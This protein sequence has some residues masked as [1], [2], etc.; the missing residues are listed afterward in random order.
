MQNSSDHDLILHDKKLIFADVKYLLTFLREL[1]ENESHY[2][3]TYKRTSKNSK[4]NAQEYH[5][6][7]KKGLLHALDVAVEEFNQNDDTVVFHWG[8]YR[9]LFQGQ[10]GIDEILDNRQTEA[11]KLQT[12][13]IDYL[14]NEAKIVLADITIM[15]T[16][17]R[18]LW[19]VLAK[20]YPH[21]QRHR[22]QN[23][24]MYFPSSLQ[25]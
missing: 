24:Q 16:R 17:M 19:F 25:I 3:K 12:T 9:L 1:T 18:R 8:L 20:M 2:V 11:E 15:E 14:R 23:P 13:G 21:L 4:K 6:R 10:S 22:E 5:F 7:Y